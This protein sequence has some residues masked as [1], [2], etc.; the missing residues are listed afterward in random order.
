MPENIIPIAVRIWLIPSSEIAK[1]PRYPP[2]NAMM[3]PSM[4]RIADNVPAQP[5]DEPNENAT[6]AIKNNSDMHETITAL[7]IAGTRFFKNEYL[8]FLNL[9]VFAF[10]DIQPRHIAHNKRRS[11]QPNLLAIHILRDKDAPSNMK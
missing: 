6:A 5:A 7:R 2:Y 10:I 4:P 9:I 3:I 11:D 1:I 8:F